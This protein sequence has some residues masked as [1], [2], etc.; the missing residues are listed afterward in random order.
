MTPHLL[1]MTATPIPR[2]LALTFFGDLDVSV[3][4]ELPPGRKPIVTNWVGPD[5]RGA[6]LRLRARGGAR[7]RQAFVVCPLVEESEPLESQGRHGRVRTPVDRRSSRICASACCTAACRPTDKDGACRPSAT[8]SRHPR[9]HDRHRGRHRRPQ[10]HGHAHRGRRPLRAGPAA[11]VPRPRRARRRPELLPAALRRPVDDRA[12]PPAAAWR[13]TTTASRSPKPT[14]KLRGPGE[15]FGTRQ[16][17]VPELQAADFSDVGLI[18][19][20]RKEAM[21]L[22]AEDPNLELPDH[23]LL[24]EAVVRTKRVVTGEVG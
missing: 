6:G 22:L 14:S 11:P 4:D 1:V 24:A 18:E 3:I 7:G 21:A 13:T 5:E 2:T 19:T 10:R 9:L 23:V 8:A 17:G 12:R 16:S 20:A 15:F